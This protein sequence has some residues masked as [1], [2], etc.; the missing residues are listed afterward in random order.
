MKYARPSTPT[1]RTNG[2]A[3]TRNW[4]LPMLLCAA[5]LAFPP[6]SLA[7]PTVQLS[8]SLPSPQPVGALVTWTATASDSDPGILMYSF[9]NGPQ[10]QLALVRDFGYLNSFPAYPALQEGSYQVQ[11]TV[12]NN[13]TGKTATTSQTFVATVIATASNPVVISP[14]ANPL[15]ALFSATGCSAPDT[16][17]VGFQNA[18]QTAP[19]MT[20]AKTCNGQT[21]NFYVAG[22][23]ASTKYSMAGQVLLS[24]HN[25]GHT[26]T[27]AFTTGSIPNSVTIPAFSV[28]SAAPAAATAEPILVHSY[29]FSPI[30]QTGTDLA[31]KVLW[32]YL[33]YDGQPGFISRP[34][35]GGFFWYMGDVNP[36]PYKQPL[37]EIDIA[38]NTAVE[39]NVGRINEQLVASGQ[40]ALTDV[41]HEVRTLAN[42]NIL[43]IG[44]LDR[45][46]GPHIQ[47][48]SD[49]IFQELV[50]LNPG[51]Q[52]LW[53]W[54]AVTCGNCATELPTARQA[55]LHETCEAGFE[56]CPPLTPPNTVANDWLHS[57]S[58]QLAPDGN[59]LLSMRHQDWVIKIDYQNG[60]GT[61]NVLWRLG[62]DGDFAIVG[63]ANDNYP[64]FSHQHDVE[65]EFGTSYM[66]L[67]DNGN[68]RINQNPTQH[69]RG[70]L[71]L[72]DEATLTAT[73]KEN[74]D[75][76]I[77]SLAFGSAQELLNAQGKP[78]GLHYEAGDVNGG[79][80]SQSI[81]FYTTGTLNLGSN[82]AT[83]RSAQMRDMYTPSTQP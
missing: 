4:M 81:S 17:V 67:F 74:L 8:A 46:L 68:T 23:Y 79:Q 26:A 32:Y 1:A 22:M 34:V 38:G 82:T 41:D 47:N 19:Q 10:G 28:L 15:V 51:L 77:K 80:N 64:W 69:S 9:S 21:M 7:T 40:M 72:V 12:R 45:V 58:A 30:V 39:T 35:A 24:G 14:T 66:S 49:I 44:S 65:Y 56:G 76:G 60:G 63:D 11:V 42:G 20:A 16:M 5:A 52:L 73:L 83:Y 59:L 62:L 78:I 13:N 2:S 3:M 6:A 33:P 37:R 61:G 70:Q 31:G 25:V 75:L 57:N 54:N 71:L 50:V 18:T 36:D 43:M 53:S 48:G 55:I 29:I 27:K